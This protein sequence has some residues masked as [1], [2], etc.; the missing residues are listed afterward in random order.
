MTMETLPDRPAASKTLG[1]RQILPVVVIVC[2]YAAGTAAVLPV[3]PFH[4]REMG[5]AR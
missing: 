3:L 5:A 4:I 1:W 2:V